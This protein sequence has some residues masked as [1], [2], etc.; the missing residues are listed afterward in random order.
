MN[1]V[2]PINYQIKEEGGVSPVITCIFCYNSFPL[3]YPSIKRCSTPLWILDYNWAASVPVRVG[4]ARQPW[5]VREAR[6]AHLYP[7]NTVYWEDFRTGN[8]A[9]AGGAFFFKGGERAG[10]DKLI[11]QGQYY[12]KFHDTE[13][14]LGEILKKLFH[15][16]EQFGDQCFRAAQA[17][18][19]DVFHTLYMSRHLE[20]EDYA[21]EDVHKLE[22]EVAFAA[23]VENYI[24]KHFSEK[25]SLD[26]IAEAFSMSASTLRSKFRKE[27]K[28][29]LMARLNEIRIDMAKT[30]LMKGEKI[31]NIATRIGFSD[32]FHLSKVFKKVTGQSPREF[33]RSL[34]T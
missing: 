13:G 17:S 22:T 4:S 24:K 31:C 15:L 34:H 18:M 12:A 21:I 16:P 14:K 25:L 7:P 1:T 27:Q 5:R 6:T 20:K 30:S 8:P 32:E 28:I 10:L 19:W 3:D 29:S 9:M 2:K 11:P 33:I 26:S 23:Q